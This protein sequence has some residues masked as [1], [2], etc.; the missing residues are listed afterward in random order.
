[1]SLCEK[2]FAVLLCGTMMAS[3][4][5]STAAQDAP[6][7]PVVPS[8]SGAVLMD[9]LKQ[10]AGQQVKK[11]IADG[12]VAA[13]DAT[14]VES[15]TILKAVTKVSDAVS[16]AVD[17]NVDSAFVASYGTWGYSLLY[18]DDDLGRLKKA[19][20]T[21]EANIGKEP[22]EVVVDDEIASLIDQAEQ[23]KEEPIQVSFP[24]FHLHSIA[25]SSPK[26]W[27]IWL[28][29]DMIS[30]DKLDD[31]DGLE[32][33]SISNEKVD[34]KWTLAREIADALKRKADA[35][36][37]AGGVSAAG[38]DVAT[39]PTSTPSE[40]TPTSPAPPEDMAQFAPNRMSL[41]KGQSRYDEKNKVYY[42]T[43]RANQVFVS[44][45]NSVYE[46]LPK[47]LVIVPLDQAMTRKDG[48]VVAKDDNAPARGAVAPSQSIDHA[49]ESMMDKKV[50]PKAQIIRALEGDAPPPPAAEPAK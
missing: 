19:L 11:T 9:T 35:S 28:N 2:V 8:T 3:V 10:G 30:S 21:Y 40:V 41:A 42:F 33:V 45:T 32:V 20:N 13:A 4:I 18:N 25:Y 50:S 14:G 31:S 5:G 12:V 24:S 6:P 36:K 48:Q 47:G 1:M 38:A 23:K 43:L 27:S 26:N 39:L 22:S 44:E 15:A 37:R 34:F 17:S 46:G 29:S 16:S 7:P 49:V